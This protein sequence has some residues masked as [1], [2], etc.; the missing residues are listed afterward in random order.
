MNTLSAD[1]V[2]RK[3]IPCVAAEIFVRPRRGFS[4]LFVM[5]ANKGSIGRINPSGYCMCD[6]DVFEMIQAHAA[7]IEAALFENRNNHNAPYGGLRQTENTTDPLNL[8]GQIGQT[9][10]D[11][12]YHH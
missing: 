10:R 7:E 8:P 2:I 3:G 12:Y 9:H 6:E 5:H 4:G 1:I 11:K